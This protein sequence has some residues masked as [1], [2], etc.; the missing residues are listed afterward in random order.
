MC[1]CVGCHLVSKAT[2]SFK[3]ADVDFK[4]IERI[5]SSESISDKENSTRRRVESRFAPL[6]ARQG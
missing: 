6:A 3:V 5:E 4:A 1:S 2:E